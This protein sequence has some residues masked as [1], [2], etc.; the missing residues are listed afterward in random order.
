[1]TDK[2]KPTDTEI[3][4]QIQSWG[5]TQMTY[6]IRN[7]LAMA[8][9][10]GLKTDWVRRQLVRMEKAGQVKRVPSVYAR[11]ICWALADGVTP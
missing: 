2:S 6:V 11:Q 1:M 5:H 8:G 10:K 9:H 7:G 4:A 3:K